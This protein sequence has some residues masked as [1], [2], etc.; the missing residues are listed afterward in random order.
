MSTDRIA[1]AWRAVCQ[2]HPIL[3]TIF[4]TG[5][6][7]QGA[8]QQIVLKSFVPSISVKKM[9]VDRSTISHVVAS[10]EKPP[11]DQKKPPHHLALY[12]ESASVVYAVLDISHTIVDARTY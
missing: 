7:D 2:A 6:S 9:P 4:T 11:L 3:R 8:F 1:D 10:Q 5:L 12:R